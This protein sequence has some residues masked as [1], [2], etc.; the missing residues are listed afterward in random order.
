MY[1]IREDQSLKWW[2]SINEKEMKATHKALSLEYIEDFF[3]E[4][5]EEFT[6]AINNCNE[7]GYICFPIQFVVCFVCYGKGNHVNPSVDSH[8]IT[9]EEFEN[10]WS[11]EERELYM[12]GGYNVTCY[13]C[14]GKRVVPEL[15]ENVPECIK[16]MFHEYEQEEASY[17]RVCR[18]ERMM[19]C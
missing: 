17:Q 15:N 9:G 16:K 3:E 5:S 2:S 14:N 7:D 18:Y 19:G 12:N 11:W 8:G 10:E 1:D 6:W 4:G 13:L